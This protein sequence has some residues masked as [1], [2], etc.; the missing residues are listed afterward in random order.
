MNRIFGYE[1]EDIQRAQRRGR[2]Q[3]QTVDTSKPSTPAPTDEDRH[4]LV[5][6]GSLEALEAAGFYGAA[7]RLRHHG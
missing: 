1:W 5:E 7:D 6:H 3:T 4:L 2:L